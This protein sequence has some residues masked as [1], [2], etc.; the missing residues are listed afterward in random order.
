AR[1]F[2]AATGALPVKVLPAGWSFRLIVTT[3]LL[4]A[5]ALPNRSWTWTVTPVGAYGGV[6]GMPLVVWVAFAEFG[7]VWN[8]SCFAAPAL[9]TKR[10]EVPF[11]RMLLSDASAVRVKPTPALVRRTS[12]KTACPSLMVAVRLSTRTSWLFLVTRNLA[13]S[14][15]SLAL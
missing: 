15:S 11:R 14:G 9:M 3:A 10:L 13:P 8:G 4:S 7:G 6:R 12:L 5:T 1:P 2:W